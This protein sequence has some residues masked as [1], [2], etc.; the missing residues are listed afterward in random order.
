M[1][2]VMLEVNFMPDCERACEYYPDFADV[3][4]RT[5]FKS[6]DFQKDNSL[7]VTKL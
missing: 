7:V 6:A 1:Q 5:L 4:F 2:P 3:V